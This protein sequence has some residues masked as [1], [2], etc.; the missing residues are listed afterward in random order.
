MNAGESEMDSARTVL[1][2]LDEHLSLGFWTTDVT[3]RFTSSGGGIIGDNS[4]VGLSLLDFFSE[5]EVPPVAAHRQALSGEV[6]S[7]D[8]HWEGRDLRVFLGPLRDEQGGIRGVAGV[9]VDRHVLAA[10]ARTSGPT[11]VARAHH[12]DLNPSPPPEI[13]LGIVSVSDLSIDSQRYE[14]TKGGNLV[15]VSLTE[16]KLLYELARHSGEVLSR[17]VLAERVWGHPSWTDSPALTM[18]ISR[19]RDKIE[20]DPANPVIIQTVRGVGYRLGDAP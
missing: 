10:V 12:E 6:T 2:L 3:M 16:F 15:T 8:V 13:D 14:V 20:D 1:A 17:R 4:L 5:P 19:L 18:A 9:G 7:T 11:E